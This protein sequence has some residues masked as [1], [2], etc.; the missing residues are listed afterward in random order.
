MPRG[1]GRPCGQP[2]VKT[3]KSCPLMQW[4]HFFQSPELRHNQLI[5]P[6]SK[7]FGK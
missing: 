3:D 6:G 2:D 5:P 4:E 1:R 7:L